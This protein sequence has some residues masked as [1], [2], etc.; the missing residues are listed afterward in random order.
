MACSAHELMCL[1]GEIDGSGVV[2]VSELIEVETS[3]S[4]N[5]SRGWAVMEVDVFS[6][7]VKVIPEAKAVAKFHAAEVKPTATLDLEIG[8]SRN[9]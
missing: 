4:R 9:K 1:W 5:A 3:F 7:P 6:R 8:H 2:D